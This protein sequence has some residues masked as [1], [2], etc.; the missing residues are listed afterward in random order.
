MN[1]HVETAGSGGDVVLIH[2]WGM[3]GGVWSD[4][5]DALTERYRVHVVDLPGMG[6]SKACSPYDLKHVAEVVASRLP[7]RTAI[8]GWSL[9]GQVA[10]RLALDHPQQVEKLVLIGATP[11]FVNG[12]DWQS[13]V[14]AEVFNLFASQ[15][16]ADYHDTMTRF[17]GLQAFGGESS[18]MLMRELKERFFARPVPD[19]GVLQDA[20][21]ILLET[22]LRGEL[23][24]LRQPTLLIH[25]NRDTLAPADASRFMAAHLPHA[26]LRII[27]G[28]SHAP[29][30]SHPTTFLSEAMQFLASASTGSECLSTTETNT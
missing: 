3:H 27:E 14:A 15:V 2:G 19:S 6:W 17:L 28:A 20:L 24:D 18:R 7:E 30:L 8:F 1:L 9:G 16:A 26:R 5:R 11:R 23:P 13:G 10:M 25:G 21:R 12:A 22:D 4:V 29:F